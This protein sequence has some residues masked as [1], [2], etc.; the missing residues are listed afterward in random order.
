MI[1]KI[2]LRP[3]HFVFIL[4]FLGNLIIHAQ[5]TCATSLPITINGACISNATVNDATQNAPTLNADCGAVSFRH[6][7]WYTFTVTGGPLDVSIIADSAD[8]D[9]YLQLVSSTAACTGLSQIACTNDDTNSNAAQTETLDITLANGTY[10]LKV[11][12]VGGGSSMILNS[13]CITA[14][15]NPCSAPTNIA[16]C[17]TIL[18]P[19]IPSGT[20]M[21]ANQACGNITS[22]VEMIYTFTPTTTGNYT[23]QQNSSFTNINY[24][25]K[26]VSTGCNGN[27]WSCIANLNG[28]D[29]SNNFI[30]TAGVQYYLLLDPETSTGGS[31]SFSL[32]CATPIL[33]NDECSNATNLSVN[34]SETCTSTATGNTSS[35]TESLPGCSGSADDDVWYSFTALSTNQIITV[36]PTTLSDAVFEVFDGTCDNLVSLLCINDTTG[37]SI[38]TAPVSGLIVGNTYYIRVYSEATSTGQGSFSI[39]IASPPNPC[40]SITEIDICGT[41]INQVIPAGYGSYNNFACGGATNGIE[42]IY[43]FTPTQNGDYYIEQNSAFGPIDY[44]IRLADGG[45]NELGWNCIANLSGNI[46]S[47]YIDLN[48]GDEYYI[49]IDPTNINGGTVNFTL[50]CRPPTPVNDQCAGAITL[51]VNPT[52]TCTTSTTGTT[53]GA[54]ESQPACSGSADDDVWYQFIATNP[55]HAISVTPNTLYDAVFEVF[56]GTCVGGLNSWSC[57]DTT[58]ANAIEGGVISG[59]TVGATYYV[60]VYSNPLDIGFGTFSIC[61]TTPPNP[62]DSLPAVVSCGNTIS[63]TLPSGYGS[64]GVSGCGLLTNG[65]ERLY[66]F[67]PATTASYSIVQNNSF[68]PI[69]YQFKEAT[70]GCDE[71]NWNCIATMN[72]AATS[73]YFQLTAGVEYFFLAD[74]E[75]TSGGNFSFE[76]TC[77]VIPPDNDEPCNAIPLTVS[78]VCNYDTYSNTN[79]SNSLFIG[80]PSCANYVN[81]DVWFSVVVPSTGMVVIDT[82]NGDVTNSGV[83]IYEGDCNFMT[84]INCDDDSSSNPLM[85]IVSVSSRT[86][87][88][89]L[90]VRLWENGGGDSGNFGICVT[91]PPSCDEPTDQATNFVLGTVNS[92]TISG[93]FTGSASGYLIVQSTLSTPPLHPVNNTIYNALNIGTLG[94][95]YTFVANSTTPNFTATEITG[96]T[97]YYYYIY[98]FN[99]STNCAGPVYSPLDPLTYDIITCVTAPVS[100]IVNTVTAT[101]FALNWF[102]PIGGSLIPITYSIEV[103][104]DAGFSIPVLGSPF[105][106]LNPTISLNVTGLTINTTYYYRIKATT[107]S[108][109]SD[110]VSGSVFTGYCASN[111]FSSTRYI[112]DFSTSGGTTNISNNGSGFSASGYGPFLSQIVTQQIYG[113]INFT[114]GFFNGTFPYGFNIWVDWNDDL[115]FNDAGEKVYASG[116]FVNSAI[117]SFVVPGNTTVGQHRMRIK[118]DAGSLNPLPCSTISNGETEDYTLEVTPLPCADNPTSLS[119]IFTSQTTATISWVAPTPAPNN[120]YD[121]Y[122]STSAVT[123]SYLATPTGNVATGINFINL[124]GL[125]PAF[126]YYFWV[127]SYCDTINGT[128]VWI[129]PVT[130][131]QSNCTSGNGFGTTALGC[132]SV[133]AGGLNLNGADPVALNSCNALGCVDIEAQYLHLGDTSTYTVQSIPYAPPYQYGCLANPLSINT[134]DVWSPI[135][136]LPFNFCYYGNN[137]NKCLVSSNGAIS[138][139]TVSNIPGGG[140]AWSFNSNIPNPFLFKNA[141]FGVYQDIHPGVGGNIGWELITLNTGCRALVVS[142]KNVPM[143]LCTSIKYTGMMVLYENTNIIE[144]YIQEKTLCSGWNS[145]NALVGIQDATGTQGIMAPNRGVDVDWAVTNEAWR[146]VPSGNS[147]TSIKWHE[148]SGTAGPVIATTDVL[149]V[150]PT[151]TTTY[152]AEITYSLCNG[153]TLVETDETIVSVGGSKTW[154]GAI[155]TDWNNSINW[156]PNGIPNGTDCVVIPQTANNPIISGTGYNG[157]A[158]TL[159]VLNNASL[160]VNSQNNITVTNWVAVQPDGTFQLENSSNLIQ[161]N[162]DQN[163]GNILYKRNA[164]IRSLDYVYWSSPVADFNVDNIASPLTAGAIYKWNTTV[165]NANGGQGNWESAFGETMIAAKGYI[166]NGPNSF[167]ATVPATLFGQFTGVPNNGIINYTISRGDDVNTV[168]HLGLNGTE[169]T[170]YSDNWNLIGNPY[171]SSISGGQF[172]FNNS[173]AIAGNIKLWTHGS[174]PSVSTS[175]FYGTFVYN[176]SPGDYLTYNYT[177]TS[178]CPAAGDDVFI[179]AGQGFF[180]QMNDGPSATDVVTFDNALRSSSYVNNIFYRNS[181]DSPRDSFVDIERHRIWLDL[182]DAT[183]KSERTLVGYIEGATSGKDNFFDAATQYTGSLSLY[184]LIGTEKFIIQGRALSFDNKDVIPLGVVIP[185]SGKYTIAIGAVDGLFSNQSRAIYLEDTVTKKLHNLKTKPYTF[186]ATSGIFNNRFKLRFRDRIETDRNIE[187][188]N[189]AI[190]S[191]NHQIFAESSVEKI[192]ELVVFDI[193]GRI[194]YEVKNINKN[195]IVIDNSVTNSQTLIVKTTLENGEIVTKKIL[196]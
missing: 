72:N 36:T 32:T 84:E 163:T 129:G 149:N 81:N 79:A 70:L 167:S 38:E 120:G 148:G 126:T 160:T 161:I 127:R 189:V 63:E 194:I 54:D 168:Y 40:L 146:F 177:G 20:G 105:T 27:N 53:I 25:F 151:T 162:N 150:C 190:Y 182:I 116:S 59:L 8:R 3:P 29:S 117:G 13:L 51:T 138:F 68:S 37:S 99:N 181:E 34:S 35:A 124:T 76:I 56:E 130:F 42:H 176:Y 179:G 71:N 109:S 104:T 139:D 66:S 175:P 174:L 62:C 178:C 183:S 23:I 14:P 9:L 165:P 132:P 77:G 43:V 102:A 10:Y 170:N 100:V 136:N 186:N 88:E 48:S 39:C 31:I 196:L 46:V 90:Y 112:T 78:L 122:Y 30:L 111:S 94:S 52:N 125:N 156:T 135:V 28:A 69:D 85:S 74:P 16:N 98:A 171:P 24:Q 141:I 12:N 172:L 195:N 164:N 2:T 180:V 67:T 143:Y 155:D 45:C 152:T 115:D 184:S 108:C 185:T 15:L 57:N 55:T 145:G 86:P 128:G 92:T 7:R 33:Y 159:S 97:H 91:T 19:N 93:S 101:S 153:T 191:A 113:T 95:N 1:K 65:I 6:E 75:S 157:L 133:T 87:G 119:A 21:F 166:A 17:D 154:N 11:V 64:Y 173:S 187:Q 110:Y 18:N 58:A 131:S 142:W 106:V 61:V 96:N 193:V 83:A 26:P 80:P 158:G 60:R 134:D 140:S 147:L 192:S 73:P 121:Y 169:I 41:T 118:A 47:P 89:V 137:Y 114:A 22:G 123:P 5:N 82:Q 49:M 50:A 188:S 144:V 44:Q 4:F 103:A 107:A